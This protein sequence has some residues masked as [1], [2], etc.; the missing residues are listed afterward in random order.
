MHESY[1]SSTT[2]LVLRY[3]DATLL[4]G[5]R[6]GERMRLAISTTPPLL[7]DALALAVSLAQRADL[8]PSQRLA[9]HRW[10]QAVAAALSHRDPVGLATLLRAE[11]APAVAEAVAVLGAAVVAA[12]WWPEESSERWLIEMAVRLDS[13]SLALRYASDVV[14]VAERWEA[15]VDPERASPTLPEP[16][17]GSRALRK[18]ALYLQA[19][20]WQAGC[21]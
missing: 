18:A 12:A 13:A 9:P 10:S 3:S 4:L 14:R 19:D 16:D 11:L 7:T 6:Q 5:G 20:R 2:D 1:R 21:W 15:L 8:G 17:A